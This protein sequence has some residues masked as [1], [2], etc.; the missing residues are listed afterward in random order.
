MFLVNSAFGSG[1]QEYRWV[2]SSRPE[3]SIIQ[4]KMQIQDFS[5][6]SIRIDG[7]VYDHDVIIDGSQVHRR[8]KKPSK[9]F[10]EQYGHTP[11][12]AEEDLPWACRY[13]VI[14]TGAYGRLPVMDQVKEAAK[15]HNVELIIAPTAQA[16]ETLRK[17]P[18]HHNAI[19]HVTC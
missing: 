5:F 15:K 19:L 4:L 14:G 6:G 8:K 10:K 18:A 1:G 13:L 17:N 9:R 12:S 11:L 7:K 3:R 2:E 16:I